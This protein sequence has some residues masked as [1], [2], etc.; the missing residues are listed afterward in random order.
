MNDPLKSYLRFSDTDRHP[1]TPALEITLTAPRNFYTQNPT[2]NFFTVTVARSKEHESKPCHFCWS[3]N[4]D[5]GFRVFRHLPCGGLEEVEVQLNC[6]SPETQRSDPLHLWSLGADNDDAVSWNFILGEKLSRAVEKSEWIT[7]E[8]FWP[9]GEVYLWDWEAKENAGLEP[10]SIPMVLPGGARCSF[11][12]IEGDVPPPPP[13]PRTPP[14]LDL[15]ATSVTPG[16]P[17]LSLEIDGPPTWRVQENWPLTWKLTYHGVSGDETPQPITFSVSDLDDW[18]VFCVYRRGQDTGEWDSWHSYTTP[19]CSGFT[20]EDVPCSVGTSEAF[21]SLRPNET[22][23]EV[24]KLEIMHSLPEDA[25]A[26]EVLRY[27]LKGC[28]LTWWNWGTKEDHMD[29]TVTVTGFGDT[30]IDPP[31]NDGRSEVVIP[32]SNTVEFTVV[33]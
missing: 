9:G 14:V 8:L 5:E 30:I 25:R 2:G 20:E 29:T 13:R 22:W 33:N 23:C 31:D 4:T 1:H 28:K 21:M 17:I 12:L 27:R 26:K 15:D 24:Q 3:P 7:Y 11:S 18:G 19:G 32:A 16:T 10:K 6:F